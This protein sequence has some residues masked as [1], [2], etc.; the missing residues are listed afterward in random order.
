MSVVSLH[1]AVNTD[2]RRSVC[3]FCLRFTSGMYTVH[4]VQCTAIVYAQ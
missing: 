2:L 1:I 3:N 4:S